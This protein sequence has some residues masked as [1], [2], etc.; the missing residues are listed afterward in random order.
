MIIIN[1]K[2]DKI[3]QRSS[4]DTITD[5]NGKYLLDEPANTKVSL[6]EIIP[7]IQ[8][9]I[10]DSFLAIYSDYTGITFNTLPVKTDFDTS[11]VYLTYSSRC[12]LGDDYNHC[13]ILSKNENTNDPGVLIT[14]TITIPSSD[15]F[16]VY[17]KVAVISYG[18]EQ[19]VTANIP[20]EMIY[21]ILEPTDISV[22]ISND[23]GVSYTEATYLT[24][25]SFSS[26]STTMRIAFVNN[27]LNKIHLLGYAILY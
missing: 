8:T 12:Q 6:V 13:A 16:L 2:N 21:S 3:I 24:P 26:G 5:M 15:K 27:S 22:Y 25:V 20:S 10:E 23:D 7:N 4:E 9:N 1:R 19:S 17:W 18:Q 11:A 14:D